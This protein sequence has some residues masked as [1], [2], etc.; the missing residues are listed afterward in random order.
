MDIGGGSV[1]I[2]RDMYET[3]NRVVKAIRNQIA[4]KT[5]G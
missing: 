1:L 5:G 3:A 2:T 4:E